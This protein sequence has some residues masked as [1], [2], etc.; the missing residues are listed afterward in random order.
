MTQHMQKN[1]LIFC[2]NRVPTEYPQ[3]GMK[4][5]AR[6]EPGAEG[7]DAVAG[8]RSLLQVVTEWKIVENPGNHRKIIEN[9]GKIVFFP[10]SFS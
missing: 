2:P 5:V 8:R 1:R 9:H 3:K 7:Q 6:T 10:E 4:M